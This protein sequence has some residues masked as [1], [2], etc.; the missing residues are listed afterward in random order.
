MGRV[1]DHEAAIPGLLVE[2]TLECRL[3]AV[4]FDHR[5]FEIVEH[6]A[7]RDAAKDAPGFFE[8]GDPCVVDLLVRDVECT[9]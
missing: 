3:E 5:R 1:I 7:A 4:G 8:Y 6:D 2:G 9:V